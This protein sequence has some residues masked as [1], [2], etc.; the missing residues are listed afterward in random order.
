MTPTFDGEVNGG[1]LT[2]RGKFD[3]Y[4]SALEGPVRV[5]VGK[6]K[7][8][9]SDNQNR[10]YW[11]CVVKI[12]GDEFGYSSEEMHDAFKC[13]FLRREEPGK[14]MTLGSTAKMST[15]E[16]SEYVEGCRRWCSEHGLVIPDPLSY[17]E[18]NQ[19]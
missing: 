13:L 17:Y 15:A 5:T 12:A 6:R 3:E 2:V 9:R 4:L 7:K 16:F 10:Y 18:E 8:S 1:K 14:P 11:G 19:L